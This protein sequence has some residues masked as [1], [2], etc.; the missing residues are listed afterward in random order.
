[1]TQP[2]LF[3]FTA[4]EPALYWKATKAAIKAKGKDRSRQRVWK[5]AV[6]FALVFFL[7][8]VLRLDVVQ[9]VE[10]VLLAGAFIAG[11]VVTA[12]VQFGNVWLLRARL[13]S[14]LEQTQTLQ[15]PFSVEF[16]PDGCRFC[17]PLSNSNLKWQAVEEIIDLRTGTGLRSGLLVY[18]LPNDALPDGMSPEDFRERLETWRVES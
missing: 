2:I 18:P 6:W 17:S 7:M 16:G 10:R 4:L 5:V 15:G 1:M 9:E 8:W 11:A 12:V 13:K 3:T 14:T